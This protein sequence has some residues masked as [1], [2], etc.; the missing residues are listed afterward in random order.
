MSGTTVVQPLGGQQPGSPPGGAPVSGTAVNSAENTTLNQAVLAQYTAAIT[1]M[2]QLQLAFANK[3][4]NADT[5]NTEMSRISKTIENLNQGQRDYFTTQNENRGTIGENPLISNLVSN[6]TN[7]QQFQQNQADQLTANIAN[8]PLAQYNADTNVKRT[9]ALENQKNLA[10]NVRDQLTQLGNARE[11][12]A[13]MVL[14]AASGGGLP[15]GTGPGGFAGTSG[16][17]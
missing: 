12:N 5:Y 14:A 17:Y 1:Q 13:K 9:M 6:A 15:G 7:R 4:I 3:E 2:G 8:N 10:S 16:R 11:T